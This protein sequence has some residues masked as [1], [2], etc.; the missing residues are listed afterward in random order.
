MLE[1]L[2]QRGDVVAD[3]Q[4]VHHQ[5]GGQVTRKFTSLLLVSQNLCFLGDS[6]SA[7][8]EFKAADAATLLVHRRSPLDKQDAFSGVQAIGKREEESASVF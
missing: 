2:G 7:C 5:Q 4:L 8:A 3:L 1:R 6:G